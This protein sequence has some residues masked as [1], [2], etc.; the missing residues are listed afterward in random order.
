[1][2]CVQYFARYREALGVTEESVDWQAHWQCLDDLRRHLL[3]RGERWAVLGEAS[4]MCARNDELCRLDEPL[5]DDDRVAFFPP[6]TG[7]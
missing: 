5:A 1:M 7:G 4:L 2:I 3:G 6:V